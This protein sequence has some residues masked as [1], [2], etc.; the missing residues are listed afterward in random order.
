M[1]TAKPKGR[2]IEKGDGEIIYD[3]YSDLFNSYVHLP[4]HHLKEDGQ[5]ISEVLPSEIRH[6]TMSVRNGTRSRQNKTRTPEE[7]SASTHQHPGEA[8]YTISVGMQGS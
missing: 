7:P 8:L 4:P 3:F 2:C 1:M 6:A 5:V